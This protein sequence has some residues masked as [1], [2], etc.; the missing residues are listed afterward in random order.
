MSYHELLI[1]YE[2]IKFYHAD[3]KYDKMADERVPIGVYSNNAE[4]DREDTYD[5]NQQGEAVYDVY[6][7]VCMS[8]SM[9]MRWTVCAHSDIRVGRVCIHT[10]DFI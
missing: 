10:R 9:C 4:I 8:S 2:L 3:A 6:G 1:L 5:N 7:A